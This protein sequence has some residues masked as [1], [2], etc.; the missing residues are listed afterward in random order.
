MRSEYCWVPGIPAS[1]A[2]P[3]NPQHP[4]LPSE[5]TSASLHKGTSLIPLHKQPDKLHIICYAVLFKMTRYQGQ[6]H[7]KPLAPASITARHK[8]K[9]ENIMPNITRTYRR[10]VGLMA[11]PIRHARSPLATA[12]HTTKTEM[13]S[14]GLLSKLITILHKDAVQSIRALKMLGYYFPCRQNCRPQISGRSRWKTTKLCGAINTVVNLRDENGQV[15][16][17]KGCAS[18]GMGYWQR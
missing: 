11:Y 18:D 9:R 7:T 13:M 8:K 2:T 16:K 6:G 1:G 5:I 15:A 14:F 3:G 17:L 10:L 12:L 4:F